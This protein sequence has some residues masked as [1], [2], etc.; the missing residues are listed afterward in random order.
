MSNLSENT[1][2]TYD[3]VFN[4]YVNN[5]Y[6]L[7]PSKMIKHFNNLYLSDD[8]IRLSISSI[9]YYL[10]N[11]KLDDSVSAEDLKKVIND[12]KD[13]LSDIKIKKD[14]EFKNH[15]IIKQDFIP[16]F[17]DII[18]IRENYK[19]QLLN[20]E[21]GGASKNKKDIIYKKYLCSCIY[22]YHPPRR[23]LD[24]KTMIIMNNLND[25][26]KF[27]KQFINKNNLPYYCNEKATDDFDLSKDK[28]IN[29]NFYIKDKGLFIFWNYKTF[30]TY[31]CQIIKV[32]NELKD[33]INDY[34]D[35]FNLK[36]GDLL[37]KG[38]NF[39][40][41][42][43]ETFRIDGKPVSINALRHSFINNFYNNM[44]GRDIINNIEELSRMMAHSV[45]VNMNY[46]K[47]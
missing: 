7:N 21:L 26:N 10:K 36:S 47:N 32:D 4:H 25:Y 42:I 43:N 16:N 6:L 15:D 13:I 20:S 30:K 11:N 33:I 31:K 12:Y 1:L 27:I 22:T 38:K 37:F 8:T 34:I 39:H 9:L 35:Y 44:K 14:E 17:R 40:L 24:Y 23:E 45:N 41:L 19:N 28:K 5:K 3:Y 46:Y 18:N 2:K 29:Y